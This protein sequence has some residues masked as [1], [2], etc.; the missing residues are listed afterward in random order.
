LYFHHRALAGLERVRLGPAEPDPDRQRPDLGRLVDRARVAGHVQPGDAQ[1]AASPGDVHHR[2]QHRR[3][4]SPWEPSGTVAA[5]LEALTPLVRRARAQ[6]RQ[7]ITGAK[8]IGLQPLS[9]SSFTPASAPP[10]TRS[11]RAAAFS[12]A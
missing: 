2:V 4:R 3:R 1:P 10:M 9:S 11:R 5:G 6:G 12:R 8:V 7:V